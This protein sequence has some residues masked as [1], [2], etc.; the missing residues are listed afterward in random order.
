M[1]FMAR[2]IEKK[3]ESTAAQKIR[4]IARQEANKDLTE[5]SQEKE[6]S[7]LE[8]TK[9]R[10]EDGLEKYD[11]LS[12]VDSIARETLEIMSIGPDEKSLEEFCRR[13]TNS[14]EISRML[15]VENEDINQDKFGEIPPPVS[16]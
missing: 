12:E 15:A 11:A 5:D 13:P 8:R 4:K 10:I 1:G 9:D 6:G 3:K 16:E 2:R 14:Q 7:T